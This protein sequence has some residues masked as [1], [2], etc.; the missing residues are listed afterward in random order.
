MSRPALLLGLILAA[1]PVACNKTAPNAKPA[2][3]S[4]AAGPATAEKA[5]DPVQLLAN[6]KG[7][8]AEKRHRAIEMTREMDEA[9]QDVV[10]TLLDALKDPTCGSIDSIPADRPTSTRETAVLAFLELKGKGKKALTEQ[11]LKTLE[12]GLKD[13]KPEVRAHTANAIGMIGSDARP[14]SEAVAK[15]CSDG[16]DKVRAVAYRTLQRLKPVPPGPILLLLVHPDINIAMEAASALEWLKPTGPEAVEPLLAALKREPRPKQEPSDIAFIKNRAAE[17]L[18]N[19]GKGAE[20]A[21][22]ALVDMLTKAKKEDIEAMARP[23]KP[24][25]TGTNLSGPVLALRRIGKPAAE[26]VIPLLKHDD[27]IVRFQAAAVLSGMIPGEASAA[28]PAVQTAMETERTLPN[29]E[30]YVFE[31]MLAATLHLG[32]DTERVTAEI[33]KLLQSE[34][35]IV[36]Y[37]AAKALA[38][39]GRKGAAAI[40]K[41]TELLNDSKGEIQ[42]AALEALAAMGSA[43]KDS[44]IE[45]AKKVTGD[46]VSMGR[47][48]ART[49]RAFGPAAAPAVPAL[50]NALDSNDQNFCVEAAQ[51]LTAIGPEAVGA[52]EAIAKHLEDTNSRREEK[53]ALLQAAAAIGPPAKD[54]I[55]AITK[56]LGARDTAVRVAAAETLGRVGPGN[57]DAIK[58]LA[59]PLADI[60]NNPLALQAAIL[61]ALAGMGPA[62]KAAAPEV[63]TF[64]E[65]VNDPGTKVWAAA[66]LVALGSDADANSKVVLAALRDK[67]ANAKTAR[68]TAVEAAEFLGSK[69]RPAIPDL[70]EVLQD[71][72]QLETTREKAARSLGRLGAKESVRQLTDALR[73]PD[74]S[75]RR[76]AADALGMLGPDAVT[77]APKLRDLIKSDPASADAAEA[78]LEKIEPGKKE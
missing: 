54:A 17:A 4:T 70:V 64:G 35:E 78:A 73:D 19:V 56:L 75:L 7:N 16:S 42:E 27:P 14:A 20:T 22:P 66:T 40:P 29:G 13:K 15:L 60:K 67:A 55:P 52:V 34:Q 26:A 39:I 48:A 32:G 65:K 33:I 2:S 46:D 10:P 69:G 12:G 47:E 41:L 28:L 62:A 49:L 77:A 9:G 23:R 68:G 50:A 18:A 76:A 37:R 59:A 8:N 53:V 6:L 58:S 3:T 31:E 36:R 1:L 21:V 43:A 61:K 11:G 72:A 25:D 71:K 38:R 24:G 44:V 74:K 45:I 57:A 5:Y 30:L 63:K 51:A